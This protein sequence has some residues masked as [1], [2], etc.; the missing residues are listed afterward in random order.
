MPPVN[1]TTVFADDEDIDGNAHVVYSFED[2][3]LTKGPFSIDGA[4]GKVTLTGNLDREA[5]DEY[6]V[7]QTNETSI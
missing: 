3:S 7:S 2:F 1:I 6:S 5:Q 4:T